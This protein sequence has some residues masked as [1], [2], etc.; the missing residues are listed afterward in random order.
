MSYQIK[1][2]KYKKKYLELKK[3]S[4]LQKYE[5]EQEG[6]NWVT[7]ILG[8]AVAN[9]IG[10]AF[11]GGR[12]PMANNEIIQF[13][14]VSNELQLYNPSAEY[15]SDEDNNM[16]FMFAS[17]MVLM[18]VAASLYAGT[19]Y[20]ED[21]R[22]FIEDACV[23]INDQIN[24]EQHDLRLVDS[25]Q[26]LNDISTSSLLTLA[27]L[28]LQYSPSPSDS[29]SLTVRG[30]DSDAG[31]R[32]LTVRG[33]DSSSDSRKQNVLQLIG[34]ELTD[35]KKQNQV[36]IKL[37][38]KFLKQ[39]QSL[40]GLNI[41]E[42]TRN[43]LLLHNN[44]VLLIQIAGPEKSV[45]SRRIG[46]G[47]TEK[48]VVLKLLKGINSKMKLIG[49]LNFDKDS[50]AQT[51]DNEEEEINQLANQ[52]IV[53]LNDSVGNNRQIQLAIQNSNALLTPSST[54]Q[55][56]VSGARRFINQD[57]IGRLIEFPRKEQRKIEEAI[58]K[59]NETNPQD[60]TTCPNC[61]QITSLIQ[62]GIKMLNEKKREVTELKRQ[63]SAQEY[64]MITLRIYYHQAKEE[65]RITKSTLAEKESELDDVNKRLKEAS[66][67]II[68]LE[69]KI[70]SNDIEISE[71]MHIKEELEKVIEQARNELND[72]KEDSTNKLNDLKE[73]STNKLNQ[74]VSEKNKEIERKDRQLRKIRRN[75]AEGLGRLANYLLDNAVKPNK[76]Y[77]LS[78]I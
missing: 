64:Y 25:Q 56:L 60:A 52:S 2:L 49:G 15:G 3:T 4:E 36:V 58:I 53:A 8:N 55:E 69:E 5:Q 59:I 30:Q 65:L 13:S 51:L 35:M 42:A 19:S 47:S 62:T 48:P 11:L 31:L 10:D 24:V 33:Q 73:D 76:N 26:K 57:D 67:K 39:L 38:Q 32:A 21:T 37:I 75:Y 20:A 9:F 18:T 41:L 74:T 66:E 17:T 1:Y 12:V 50:T 7:D 46:D 70:G 72:L 22:E 34:G 6:G 63:I 14:N 61:Q 27:P 45:D 16:I 68:E 77:F 44:R 29:S 71:L 54:P 78:G 28:G 43:L 23:A 40:K